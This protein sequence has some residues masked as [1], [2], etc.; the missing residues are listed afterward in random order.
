[1]VQRVFAP[2]D[3][4]RIAVREEGL[5]ALALHQVHHDPRPVGA[6]IRQVPRLT[7]MHLNG[8]V[9]SLHV[10]I[11]KARSHHQAGQLLGQILPPAG[12][13][14]IRKINFR[15]LRHLLTLLFPKSQGRAL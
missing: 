2:A 10:H 15:L 3:I 11:A 14:K 9:L 5:A 4:E 12:A 1:M 7:K 6:Q 8:D 13:A